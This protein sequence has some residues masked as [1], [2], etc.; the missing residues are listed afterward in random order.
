MGGRT[1]ERRWMVVSWCCVV[2]TWCD[3]QHSVG[4]LVYALQLQDSGGVQA[5]G[6]AFDTVSQ[7]NGSGAVSTP[8]NAAQ[9]VT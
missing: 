9:R 4:G 8:P 6:V 3:L 1:V 5:L 2:P 7:I